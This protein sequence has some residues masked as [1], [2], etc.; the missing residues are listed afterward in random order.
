MEVNAGD[1]TLT[2]CSL[3]LQHMMIITVAWMFVVVLMAAAEAMSTT[4]V[5]GLLTLLFYGIL[6]LALLLYLGR[7]FNPRKTHARPTPPPAGRNDE[8]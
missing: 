6:P 4:I 3:P 5:A 7:A 1:P 8:S 2:L